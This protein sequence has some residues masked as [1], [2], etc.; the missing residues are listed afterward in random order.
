MN[1]STMKSL[2]AQISTDT[3][4]I[5][6]TTSCKPL[7]LFNDYG[8]EVNCEFGGPYCEGWLVAFAIT[9]YLGG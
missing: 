7:S 5:R 3:T 8:I 4:P 2:I 6:P 1:Q 9:Q